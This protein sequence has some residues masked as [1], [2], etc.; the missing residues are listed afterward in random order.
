MLPRKPKSIRTNTGSA[1]KFPMAFEIGKS[2]FEKEDGFMGVEI[3]S[4]NVAEVEKAAKAED[5][6]GRD[7]AFDCRKID[8]LER[9]SVWC[10]GPGER[11]RTFINALES[12]P[13]H[14]WK[15]RP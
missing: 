13:V 11:C 10:T 14:C 1:K 12:S 5:D 9:T 3:L 4:C 8:L 15:W 2:L 6:W 7:M